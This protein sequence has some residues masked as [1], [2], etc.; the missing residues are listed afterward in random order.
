MF[1]VE[2]CFDMYIIAII[3]IELIC[4]IIMFPVGLERC[5]LIVSTLHA[6]LLCYTSYIYISILYI[7]SFTNWESATI[8][9]LIYI[10]TYMIVVSFLRSFIE[11]NHTCTKDGIDTV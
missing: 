2:S 1:H 8:N 5:R 4:N 3:L 9:E 6:V 7:S 11:T 10:A